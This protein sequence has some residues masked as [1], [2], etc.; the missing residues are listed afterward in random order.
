MSAQIAK[1]LI[2][3]FYPYA[4]KQLNFDKPVKVRYD[5]GDVSNAQNPLGKT[6]NYQPETCTITLYTLGR[7]PKDI[8]R[9]FCHELI[10]HSQCCRGEFDKLNGDAQ[11]VATNLGYAQENE[12]LRQMEEE[13]YRLSG[14][15]VR[16]WEDMLKKQ[17]QKELVMIMEND[18]NEHPEVKKVRKVLK[19]EEELNDLFKNRRL[20]LNKKLIEKF[21]KFNKPKQEEGI[22]E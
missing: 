1:K 12:H 14:I 15:L 3:A 7:H 5:F 9:S 19:D 16:D 22:E 10:H 18:E 4:K 20:D 2:H 13:A 17:K 11:P 6:G 21:T 8:L